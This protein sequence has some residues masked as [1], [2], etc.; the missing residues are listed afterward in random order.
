VTDST[1]GYMAMEAAI[2]EY[3]DQVQDSAEAGDTPAVFMERA[4]QGV[5]A[6]FAIAMGKYQRGLDRVQ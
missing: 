3:I 4:Y 1:S 2:F 5:S 6:A